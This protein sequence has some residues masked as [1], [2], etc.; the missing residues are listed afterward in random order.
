AAPAEGVAAAAVDVRL[1]AV[2]HAAAAGDADIVEAVVVE[3][4]E[5][6]WAPQA[7]ATGR[8]AIPA[9]VAR[10]LR[11]VAHAIVAGARVRAA[12][13][14]AEAALTLSILGA[15]RGDRT[16]GAATSAV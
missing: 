12:P 6:L 14:L 9:A 8:T 16:E 11:A 5:A 2:E 15:L 10:G 13:P 4:V 7:I 1:E 3:A